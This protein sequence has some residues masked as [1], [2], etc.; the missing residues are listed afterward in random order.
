MCIRDSEEVGSADEGELR[1][2]AG[3]G[4]RA[5]DGAL[6]GA[7]LHHLGQLGLAAQSAIGD[8][9]HLDGAVGALLHGLLKGQELS[10]IHISWR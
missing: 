4:V 7:K 8:Q 5:D 1:D 3:G 9:L 10:L 2:D 6:Q